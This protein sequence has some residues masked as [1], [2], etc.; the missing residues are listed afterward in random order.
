MKRSGTM[1]AIVQ[2]RVNAEGKTVR[3]LECGHEQMEGRGGKVHLAESAL[4]K[5]CAAAFD[6]RHKPKPVYHEGLTDGFLAGKV[7]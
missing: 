7:P 2:R 5:V 4:C 6:A 1:K 3:L